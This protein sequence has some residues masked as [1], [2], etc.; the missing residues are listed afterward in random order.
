MKLI[1]IKNTK[2]TQHTDSAARERFTEERLAHD[3][4]MLCNKLSFAGAEAYKLLR[5]NLLFSL[6]G[7]KQCKVVGVTSSG[8]GE[9]KSITAINLA[10]TFAQTGKKVLLVEA[11]MRLP[12]IAKR[13]GLTSTA[14]LSN[15]LA[16]LSDVESA[17]L[18][19]KDL[20]GL[21]ILAAG[22]IPPNPSE[23]LGS[24]AMATLMKRLATENDFIVMDLPPVNVVSDALVLSGLVD[25]FLMVVRQDHTAKR[26]V[27]SAVNQL[28]VSN[29][30]FLGFV[31]NQ[32]HVK[33]GR[34]YKYKRRGYGY[35]YGYRGGYG[36]GGRYG[37]GDR[38]YYGSY[39]RGNSGGSGGS[40][41]SNG[42]DGG[43]N[44]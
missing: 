42:A 7:E 34:S 23:L 43:S 9:G 17:I 44:G 1:K 3:R 13:L 11:D 16:G 39:K 14:G 22:D 18:N 28:S 40:G 8:P 24:D 31:L 37:Y 15:I 26:A 20:A 2:K 36:Y 30:R 29:G 27:I 6:P 38:Y 4:K 25:G 10:Y 41:G 32:S 12:N 19:P 35:G 21:R 5:A 33:G